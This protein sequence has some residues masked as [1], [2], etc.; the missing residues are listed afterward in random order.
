MIQD[1]LINLFTK[2]LYKAF[3]S[4]D[5]HQDMI[6][7]ITPSTKIAY[8]H[9]QCNSAM[10][11]SKQ[12]Q[13]SPRDIASQWID[14]LTQL[15]VSHPIQNLAIEKLSIAGP[16]F[17]NIILSDATLWAYIVC[18]YQDPRLGIPLPRQPKHVLVDFSSPNIAKEMHV[19][20]LR[21]TIIGDAIARLY[22][23][24]GHRVSRINHIGDWGTQFGMLIAY[25]DQK[26]PDYTYD[27]LSQ[28]STDQLMCDYKA[29]KARFDSD[30][31]FKQKAQ[32]AVVQLQQH[33]PHAIAIWQVI[34]RISKVAYDD[35]YHYLD[36]KITDRGESFYNPYLTPLMM[37]LDE[38]GLIEES[39]GAKCMTFE[40][41]HNR[42]G[43]PL[44]LILQKRDGGYNYA[45][46]DL[47]ALQ[48]R[49]KHDKVNQ[50]IYVTDS[51][52]SLH[53]S[54]VFKAAKRA[55]IVPEHVQC[56]HVPFGLVLRDDGK[57]FKTRSGDTE[58]L[59]DLIHEAI[60]RSKEMLISRDQNR[61]LNYDPAGIDKQATILGINAIK[62]ADLSTHRLSD[63]RFSYDK[64][65]Q[66]EGNTAT[67]ILYAY[68]RIQSIK[69]KIQSSESI[70]NKET[71]KPSAF[72]HDSER[73]L[74][75]YLTLFPTALK[76]FEHDLAPNRLTDYVYQLAEKFHVF[77][78][79]CRV[80]GD[81]NQNQ[82]LLLCECTSRVM[83]TCM[84]ILGLKTL[85][86]M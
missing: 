69:R 6:V 28:F 20:H 17:I 18:Y 55:G 54:M 33:E 85:E 51:G 11:L 40:G 23:F 30:P 38:A 53:F 58:K 66:F 67:F 56:D 48:Y 24:L 82:R 50:I 26:Y 5:H 47:A 42:E 77:F 1:H 62:Y 32:H 36:I 37:K 45:T 72:T 2:A 46:T 79:H 61:S 22:S 12:L 34:C 70:Q 9:F 59:I 14:Q 25:L 57:K 41:I 76:A 86:H 29:A 78:H 52:Q 3:P 68:V 49:V 80:E 84:H 16:G 19:G 64:M 71:T 83:A 43:T 15:Q 39:D 74:A 10:K 81:P 31:D 75:L 35:I 60:R 21:S 27:T 7:V 4:I 73:E 8:G 13:A 63:Y 65:L 44:P